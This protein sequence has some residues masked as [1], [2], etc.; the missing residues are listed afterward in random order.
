M[1]I[2][3][4]IFSAE[5]GRLSSMRILVAVVVVNELVMRWVALFLVG[6]VSM[7]TWNDIA[8]LAIPFGAKAAQSAFERAWGKGWEGPPGKYV[9]D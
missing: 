8:A 7:S 3:R 9:G 1:N 2:F 6:Q 5:D 4:D